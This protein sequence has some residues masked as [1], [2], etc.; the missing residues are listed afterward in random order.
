[1]VLRISDMRKGIGSETVNPSI[2]KKCENEKRKRKKK[3]KAGRNIRIYV[4]KW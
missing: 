4:R 1:M 2:L 3:I